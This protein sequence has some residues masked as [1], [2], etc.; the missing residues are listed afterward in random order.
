MTSSLITDIEIIN[1][2]LLERNPFSKPP[3]LTTNDIWAKEDINDLETL[4]AHGSDAVMKALQDIKVSK[5]ES[6]SNSI[7][8]MGAIHIGKTHLVRRIRL[9]V[10]NLK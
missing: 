6:R 3:S 2:T 10:K 9:K 8:I 1:N 7:V 4:N 5:S